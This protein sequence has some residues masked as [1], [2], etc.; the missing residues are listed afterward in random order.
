MSNGEVEG[1][2]E[3]PGRTQVERSSSRVS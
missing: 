2:A 3:A 1:P